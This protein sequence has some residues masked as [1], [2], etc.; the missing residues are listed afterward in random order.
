MQHTTY[1]VRAWN[2]TS[3][4]RKC[5][6]CGK[7]LGDHYIRVNS[8][9]FCPITQVKEGFDADCFSRWAVDKFPSRIARRMIIEIP[10]PDMQP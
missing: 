6:Q 4:E 3:I 8:Y 2:N 10:T 9:Y 7:L 1:G 5:L